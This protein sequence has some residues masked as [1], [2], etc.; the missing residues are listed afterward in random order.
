MQALCLDRR[1]PLSLLLCIYIAATSV[2]LGG[3][4]KDEPAPAARKY[5]RPPYDPNEFEIPPSTG[6]AAVFENLGKARID[7][8]YFGKRY[9]RLDLE[10]ILGASGF[11]A[12]EYLQKRRLEMYRVPRPPG[13]KRAPIYFVTLDPPPAVFEDIWVSISSGV[14]ENSW[15]AGLYF[16]ACPLNASCSKS[17]VVRPVILF[18]EAGDK[19]TIVH[20]F[21]HY[22]FN[23][24]RKNEGLEDHVQLEKSRRD[25]V[26]KANQALQTYRANG[27][28][29]HL[30]PLAR[31]YESLVDVTYKRTV[32]RE[33]E[34]MA[35]EYLLLNDWKDK[36]LLHVLASSVANTVTY[37]QENR[38]V[39]ME[40]LD[41][42]E[43]QLVYVQTESDK[44]LATSN[45][46]VL[47]KQKMEAALT[48]VRSVRKNT[49]EM[50]ADARQ[51]IGPQKAKAPQAPAKPQAVPLAAARRAHRHHGVAGCS[52]DH[53]A[54]RQRWLRDLRSIGERV[55]HAKAN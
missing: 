41:A 27:A 37:M 3:C 29:E 48:F 32:Q 42:L 36:K 35:V 10:A 45:D 21:M 2:A 31:A 46:A 38:R 33:F 20:E 30:L 52:A 4:A 17:A 11:S 26:A 44:H 54:D 28:P 18:D 39:A 40:L 9:N 5:E 22:L 50:V 47:A 16:D 34:E 24:E 1:S 15:L 23:V 7:T 6:D 43:L 25:E 8:S 12:V 53:E 51:T 19:W 13:K 49:E 14:G 55:P